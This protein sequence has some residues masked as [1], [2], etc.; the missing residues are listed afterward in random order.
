MRLKEYFPYYKRNLAIAVPVIFSQ[1]GQVLVQ[2]VDNIMVGHLGTAQLAAASFAGSVF[3]NGL[4]FG[5]GFSFGL[6]PLVG[7]AFGKGRF[8]EAA[9]LFQ[10]SLLTNLL[11]S[12]VLTLIM[13]G[14]SFFMDRMGQPAEVVKLA[15]PFYRILVISIIPFLLFFSFKQFAEGI[16]NTKVSMYITI[17]INVVNII[18]NYLLIYGKF[19][20]PHLGMIGSSVATLIARITMPVA[21]LVVFL[22]KDNFRRYFYFFRQSDFSIQVVSRLSKIGTPIGGQMIIE[23]LAFSL[24]SIMMGWFGDVPLASHQIAL[25]LATMTFMVSTGISSG[26]TIRVSHQL[27]AHRFKEMR[28]AAFASFHMVLGFMTISACLFMLFRNVLPQLFTAD[29]KVITLAAELL[30]VAGFFQIFDGL[31]VVS[32]G[33]LRGVADVKTPMYLA[34]FSYI[35]ITLPISY[36]CAFIFKLGPVGIWIGFLAGLMF[37]ASTFFLRFNRYSKSLIKRSY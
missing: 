15:V 7:K 14:L 19:G 8:R 3:I 6:T 34:F 12:F 17:W 9:R 32:L 36:L 16:G 35:V 24:G 20:F 30:I 13:F 31:Q 22:K 29:P 37:A 28:H 10:N 1:V 21:M 4:I 27:G 5:M 26:T 2:F 18:L 11:I 33:A 23:V 25:T